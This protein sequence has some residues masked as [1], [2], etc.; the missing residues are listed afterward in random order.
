MTTAAETYVPAH[1]VKV[2]AVVTLDNGR[3]VTVTIEEHSHTESGDAWGAIF[4]SGVL[5][6]HMARLV[7]KELREAR[8]RAEAYPRGGG[9]M[10]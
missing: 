2:E 1:P 9:A 4:P 5:T 6:G 10:G 8:E 7:Q 3:T